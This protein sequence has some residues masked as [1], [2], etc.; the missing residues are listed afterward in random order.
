MRIL[1]CPDSFKGS[2]HSHEVALAMR[3]GICLHHPDTNCDLAPI[4]DGGEGS[5]DALELAMG[6][7]R[8]FVETK[9]A[10]GTQIEASYLVQ[11]H[12]AY[13]ELAQTSGLPQLPMAQRNPLKTSTE[14]TGLLLR[15]ALN[16]AALEC[17]LCIGGSATNDAGLGIAHALGIKFLDASGQTFIPTGGTL[18][19]IEKVEMPEDPIWAGKPITILCDVNNPFT[20]PTGAVATFAPQKGASASDMAILERG[21][22]HLAKLLHAQFGLDPTDLPGAGAAGGVGGGLHVLL[23]ASLVPGLPYIAD[24]IDLSNRMAEA[25]FIFTGEGKL[26]HQSRSGKVIGGVCEFASKYG[27]PVIAVCGA[28]ELSASE[29]KDLGLKCAFSLQKKPQTMQEAFSNA[30]EEISYN[31]S[32]IMNLI[33]E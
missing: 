1:I 21:M 20:G 18:V 2:A 31:C 27:V 32:Q 33:A 17:V 6:G 9:N 5:L 26:D 16:S 14:G 12:I 28:I 11:D 29:I 4:A 10:V 7:D 3:E 13:I 30:I 22:M 15:S 24:R 23:Q 8:Y 25:D 19:N